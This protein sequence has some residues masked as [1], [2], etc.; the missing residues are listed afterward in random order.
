[1]YSLGKLIIR[2]H[3]YKLRIGF[4]ASALWA[5]AFYKSKCSPVCV[6]VWL[7][8]FLV[9]FKRLFT[10][11]SWIRM[12]KIF[13]DSKSLAKSSGKKWSQSLTFLL[14]NGLKLPRQK[15]LLQ[16]FFYYYVFTFEVLFKHLFAPTFGSWMSKN[17]RDLESLGKSNEKK[18]SQMWTFW[19]KNVLKSRRRK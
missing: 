8:T 1:M 3:E 12:S 6:S 16:I 11:T 5:D 9:L 7:F 2:T 18:W 15:N 17:F 10:P 19:L 14:K 4:K 13:N